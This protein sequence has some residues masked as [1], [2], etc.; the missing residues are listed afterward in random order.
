MFVREFSSRTLGQSDV[1]SDSD[2]E[3]GYYREEAL[4]L[5]DAEDE[6]DEPVAVDH[7]SDEE[8]V[9]ITGDNQRDHALEL[10]REPSIRP[11]L[12]ERIEC[13]DGSTSP[14]SLNRLP[15]HQRCASHTLNLIAT[16]DAVK[17][18]QAYKH[19][20]GGS[21]RRGNPKALYRG[22]LAI[23]ESFWNKCGQSEK[24][25]AEFLLVF[26]KAPKRPVETRW[27]SLYDAI[28][29]VCACLRQDRQ[30]FNDYMRKMNFTR[31]TSDQE[32]VL[33]EYVLVS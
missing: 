24:A 30:A 25:H 29:Q 8:C 2:I 33:E 11:V 17:A 21:S 12:F 6:E 7:D 31:L 27:N 28:L 4:V 32:A 20:G 5:S 23:L 9:D 13:P 10:N 14:P 19:T 26:N 15:P 18:F 16:T 22:A 1:A 3:D